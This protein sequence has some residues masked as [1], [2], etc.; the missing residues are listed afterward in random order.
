MASRTQH[1]KGFSIVHGDINVKV[2]LSRFEKQYEEAQ[3]ELDKAVMESME[4]F[5]P[6]V[7]GTFIKITKEI[8]DSLVGTGIVCAAAP[9]YG[10]YLYEGKVMVDSETGR[11]PYSIPNGPGEY[12]LR[13]RK[14]AELIATNRPLDY[15]KHPNPNAQDHWFDAAKAK[16]CKKWVKTVKRIAG[17]G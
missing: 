16:D 4:P 2:D 15:S 9:P 3:K 12:V 10:R 1:F 11:G 8:S 13:Y 7:T 5:M 6:Q 17:G 14:G